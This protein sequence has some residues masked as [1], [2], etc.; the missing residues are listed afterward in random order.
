M[1]TVRAD[2]TATLLSRTGASSSPAGTAGARAGDRPSRARSCSTRP[3]RAGRRSRRWRTRASGTPRRCS[4]T[5][6]CPRRGRRRSLPGPNDEVTGLDAVESLRPGLAGEALDVDATDAHHPLQ[7]RRRAAPGR[8]RPRRRRLHRRVVQSA[9]AR[10]EIFDL[11]SRPAGPRPTPMSAARAQHAAAPLLDGPVL[12]TGGLDAIMHALVR[13][14]DLRP[15][16]GAVDAD[17]LDARGPQRCTR[18]RCSR[19]GASSSP[20]ASSTP[21]S[22]NDLGAFEEIFDPSTSTW[23]DVPPMSAQRYGH[24]A[25]RLS[26]GRVL[27]AGGDGE[28][29]PGVGFVTLASAEIFDPS[30]LRWAPAGIARLRPDRAHRGAAPRRRPRPRR[31]RRRRRRAAPGPP[32][33]PAR[34]SS[35]RPR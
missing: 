22:G 27:A 15:V 25:T 34:S 32:P 1:S 24:T 14:G 7:S 31:R 5:S 10:A 11:T 20:A 4:R 30:M 35:T 28:A 12:V 19:T 33:S 23:T 29:A 6:P 26:D 9:T 18:R 8:A 2:H 3:R 21:F 17:G 16:V 13:R